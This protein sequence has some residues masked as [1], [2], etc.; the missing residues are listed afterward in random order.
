MIQIVES[1]TYSKSYPQPDGSTATFDFNVVGALSTISYRFKDDQA[2]LLNITQQETWALLTLRGNIND[3]LNAVATVTGK[4]VQVYL[5]D[6]VPGVYDYTGVYRI[7]EIKADGSGNTQIL[8]KSPTD[9]SPTFYGAK[10]YPDDYSSQLVYAYK[11]K[12]AFSVYDVSEINGVAKRVL[13]VSQRQQLD[14]SGYVSFNISELAK[15]YLGEAGSVTLAVHATATDYFGNSSEVETDPC[16][17][18]QARVPEVNYGIYTLFNPETGGEIL[19][20]TGYRL[21][22]NEA[23]VYPFYVNFV[24]NDIFGQAGLHVQLKLA[25]Y[26]ADQ[27]VDTVFITIPTVTG[28]NIVDLSGYPEAVST[29][30]SKKPTSIDVS[31]IYYTTDYGEFNGEEFTDEFDIDKLGEGGQSHAYSIPCAQYRLDNRRDFYLAYQNGFGGVSTYL[32]T[33]FRRLTTPEVNGLRNASQISNAVARET[34]TAELTFKYTDVRGINFLLGYDVTKVLKYD[35]I[36]ESRNVTRIGAGG[37]RV[38]WIVKP[39]DYGV[40]NADLYKDVAVTVYRPIG[41]TYDG[42]THGE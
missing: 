17:L 31:V 39:A 41:M 33:E 29:I 10:E 1:P 32:C 21:L 13:L 18:V 36:Y 12:V 27:L 24:T 7:A 35:G 40:A 14:A 6:T 28:L 34:E 37:T 9:E 2:K 23:Q 11:T 26:Q 20:T 30:V 25:L 19:P 22:Y 5:E 38:L 4:P 15:G 8:L 16:V 42:E 3:Y